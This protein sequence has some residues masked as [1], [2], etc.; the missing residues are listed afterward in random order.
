MQPILTTHVG[1]LPRGNELVPLL[2]A[3]DHGRPYDAEAFD[4]LVQTAVNDA[5][6]KQEAAG[7]SIASDGE[8]GKVGYSTYMTERLSGFGGNV[9]RKPALDLA[10]LSPPQCPRR[11]PK[12]PSRVLDAH[13]RASLI[14]LPARAALAQRLASPRQSVSRPRS[15]SRAVPCPTRPA[16]SDSA[17]PDRCPVPASFDGQPGPQ[18]HA[19]GGAHW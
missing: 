8:L 2:L 11:E 6:A 10:P 19:P 18:F 9:A 1:S 4:R 14:P 15:P 5:V 16:P 12:N 3:R 17:A 13:G 7:V